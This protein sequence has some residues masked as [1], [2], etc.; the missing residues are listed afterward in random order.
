MASAITPRGTPT[1]APM[2]TLLLLPSAVDGG[3][4]VAV[5]VRVCETEPGALLN[6]VL[7]DSDEGRDMFAVM[8]DVLDVTK[9]VVNDDILFDEEVA[10]DAV[11]V[12]DNAANELMTGATMVSL[13]VPQLQVS[14]APQQNRSVPWMH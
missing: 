12:I 2:T 9:E 10:G 4:E 6:V 5:V 11:S 13:P 8:E 1:P 14:S 3:L 7:L